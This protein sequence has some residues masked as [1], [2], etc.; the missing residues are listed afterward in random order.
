[1][2]SGR[3]LRSYV[4]IYRVRTRAYVEFVYARFAFVC[5]LHSTLY[6]HYWFRWYSGMDILSDWPKCKRGAI[7]I[8]NKYTEL[9]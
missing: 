2:P 4:C 9:G 7:R 6:E 8:C 1:M 5:K 3:A